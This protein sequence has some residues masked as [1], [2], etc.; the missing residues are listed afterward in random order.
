MFALS[1]RWVSRLRGTANIRGLKR[2]MLEQPWSQ[3]V[4]ASAPS[5]CASKSEGESRLQPITCAA[6][7][8]DASAF[9]QGGNCTRC[10]C[11]ACAHCRCTDMLGREMAPG[12]CSREHALRKDLK[13]GHFRSARECSHA[14]NHVILGRAPPGGRPLV[15]EVAGQSIAQDPLRPDLWRCHLCRNCRLMNS[16][17]PPLS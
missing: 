15:D 14:C 7:C 5:L 16:H 12:V 2:A 3:A 17:I 6:D 10:A 9:L 13:L 11:R 1:P 4:K 8:G